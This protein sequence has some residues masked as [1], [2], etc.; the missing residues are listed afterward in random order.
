MSIPLS[1]TCVMSFM[2]A[3]KVGT[4]SPNLSFN[5]HDNP[6]NS[7]QQK[8][9][10]AFKHFKAFQTLKI[11]ILILDIK[12]KQIIWSVSSQPLGII[13]KWRH[14]SRGRGC[15]FCDS[16]YEG[17]SKTVISAWQKGVGSGSE[18]LQICV[19]SLM[20]NPLVNSR[21]VAYMVEYGLKHWMSYFW[22]L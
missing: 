12:S 3:F 19:T 11:F 14:A 6:I 2:N 1:P 8:Q 5:N 10:L 20:N 13:H 7:A 18:N 15:H 22:L 4:P 21:F 9:V 17:L 16:I